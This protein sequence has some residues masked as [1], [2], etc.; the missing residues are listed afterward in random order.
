[1]QN[2]NNLFE[3]NE[4]QKE[5]VEVTNL[6]MQIVDNSFAKQFMSS[7]HYSG[8]CPN[9]YY[10]LGFYHKGQIVC[11]VCFGPPSGRLLAQAIM[12]GGNAKN[13]CEL[14][15]L[16]AFD[17]GPKNTESYCI[18][19]SL[20]WLQNNAP[21]MR[22]VVSYADPNQGHLG[23]IYQATNWLYTGQGSR[24]VDSYEVFMDGEWIHP[25]SVF[26]TYGTTNIEKIEEKIGHKI[27][28]R[29]CQHKHRYIY[30]LG[31]KRQKKVT[32]KILKVP[33]V[34]YP[35]KGEDNGGK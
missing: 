10:A 15:R 32:K 35:K 13:V 8:T 23:I 16:F 18:G 7:H 5:N 33:I 9:L 12:E 6:K 11:M 30:L 22:V 4:P 28:K 20:S 14:V 2:T 21:D 34:S 27:K 29:L 24:I 3:Y 31:N 25:R 19:Q 17:W 1:M 26:S